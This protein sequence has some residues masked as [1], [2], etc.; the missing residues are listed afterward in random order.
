M[1]PNLDIA[2]SEIE[3][4]VDA[5]QKCADDTAENDRVNLLAC[6]TRAVCL[7]VRVCAG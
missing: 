2:I 4:E 5:I 1:T 7:L 3:D 6:L